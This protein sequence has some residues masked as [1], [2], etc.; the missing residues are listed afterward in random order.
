MWTETLQ[1]VAARKKTDTAKKPKVSFSSLNTERGS[2]RAIP[3]LVR[4]LTNPTAHDK[5]RRRLA[6]L[7]VPFDRIN[8]AT[9]PALELIIETLAEQH[10]N[11]RNVVEL[12][13]KLAEIGR[14]D[15]LLAAGMDAE[16]PELAHY[17]S[18][19]GAA[20]RT[21]IEDGVATLLPLLEADEASVRLGS[22]R[23]LGYARARADD[24]LPALLARLSNESD[25]VV[26]SWVA[27]A[28]YQLA[29]AR[30]DTR[31]AVVEAADH[32]AM[33][34]A[35]AG[36]RGIST[37]IA[38]S[39]SAHTPED[40][41]PTV[42][43]ALVDAMD[44]FKT[45][46][47]LR[48]WHPAFADSAMLAVLGEGPLQNEGRVWG[49]RA[50]IAA[51]RSAASD[52]RVWSPNMVDAWTSRVLRWFFEPGSDAHESLATTPLSFGDLS[53]LQREMLVGLSSFENQNLSSAYE[54]FGLPP[55]MRSRRRLLGLEPK[56][57]LEQEVEAGRPLFRVVLEGYAARGGKDAFLARL[58][59]FI[60]GFSTAQRLE[61]W[62]ELLADAYESNAFSLLFAGH[63]ILTEEVSSASREEVLAWADHYRVLLT[64]TP[65]RRA[66]E[67]VGHAIV[68][69]VVTKLS[70]DETLPERFDDVLSMFGRPDRL[71]E[72]FGRM[73]SERAVAIFKRALA[74][75]SMD[76]GVTC[77]RAAALCDIRP[78]LAESVLDY[79]ASVGRA[80]I[81]SVVSAFTAARL[82]STDVDRIL[83]TRSA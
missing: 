27:L 20:I 24:I 66:R 5:A 48:P 41:V 42:A 46:D 33:R 29:L 14:P 18:G 12:A 50:V 61:L 38:A 47:P 21:A 22:A 43:A 8:E 79:F 30:P 39:F 23:L 25:G 34:I 68:H 10:P 70:D 54:L 32:A 49:G 64:S 55:D 16:R 76:R 56:T 63:D 59:P 1:P 74:D 60:V 6:D 4:D 15:A 17:G 81:S 71:R 31:R 82:V 11:R 78:L 69:S 73:S 36:A 72:I 37:V 28:A 65:D 75:S 9:G 45:A 67:T 19:S 58:A 77:E 57:V 51:G 80:P 35:A 3:G 7:L 52:R 83:K 2:A 44:P 13:L 53:E 26:F 62:T 40:A